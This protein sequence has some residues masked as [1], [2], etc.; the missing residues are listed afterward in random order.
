[1]VLA[2]IFVMLLIPLSASSSEA[3]A[4]ITVNGATVSSFDDNI[5]IRAGTEASITITVHNENSDY[6]SVLLL[7]KS[8]GLDVSLPVK[9]AVIKSGS[10]QQ[11]Y[12]NIETSRMAEHGDYSIR[13]TAK[14]YSFADDTSATGEMDIAVK[15]NS[16]YSDG[17]GYNK[18]MCI[19]PPLPAPFDSVPVT[20]AVTL[21]IWFAISVAAFFFFG[22][23]IKI[24]F[25]E[26]KEDI[27]HIK[28]ISGSMIILA[29]MV[30][31]ASDTLV[32]MGASDFLIAT[33][34]N[35]L[36]IVYILIGA[37]IV[38]NLYNSGITVFFHRM[39]AK[40]DLEGLDTS[41]IPLFRM[42]GKL[43]II[44]TAA[45][46]I[47]SIMGFD[48]TAILT[49]AGIV[50]LA[51]SLGAQNTLIQFFGGVSI[52]LTRP[53][54]TGDMVSIGTDATVYEVK[55]IGMMNTVF[56]NWANH[57]YL[58]MPNNTVSTSKITNVTGKT[59]A[60]RILLYYYSSYDTDTDLAR[61][62]ILE[63]ALK[64]PHVIQ[65][66]SYSYP[67][68]RLESFDASSIKY[69]LAVYITDFRDNVKVTGQL[70]EAVY[71]ALLDKGIECPFDIYDVFPVK[72]Q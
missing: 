69:R 67:F 17:S 1:M 59:M 2:I 7:V 13:L 3:V 10:M 21:L 15:V 55:K 39:E 61:Q 49:G 20:I 42:L 71:N 11:F 66:G 72:Q 48:L 12:I 44:I 31:A 22:F 45:S 5:E 19:F 28:K 6:A 58:I 41:L 26:A 50:T 32:I 37:V 68:V 70:N 47:L 25:R 24:I 53:F 38:W 43:V 51:V 54:K 4:T 30:H 16:A 60:Y 27:P 34:K 33:A 63:T 56:K 8:K 35:A 14:V 46:A 52:L 64:N 62:V 40:N 36:S 18:I 57:E 29:I 23:I 9:E 65:D